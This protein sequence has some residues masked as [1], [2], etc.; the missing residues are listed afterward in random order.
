MKAKIIG[1][2]LWPIIQA[3]K[4]FDVMKRK[5]VNGFIPG[6][7]RPKLSDLCEEFGGLAMGAVSICVGGISTCFA[8]ND[9]TAGGNDGSFGRNDE[10]LGK[11]AA[12]AGS[13]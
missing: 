13:K 5:I 3:S 11:T 9:G 12:A 4:V 1:I 2:W 10:N 6:S 8:G 7:K